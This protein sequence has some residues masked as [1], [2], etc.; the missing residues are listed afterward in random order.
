MN[1]SFGMDF[2]P[3]EEQEDHDR[4]DRMVYLMEVR[5]L[6]SRECAPSV[7]SLWSSTPDPGRFLVKLEGEFGRPKVAVSLCVLW[8]QVR[9]TE[10]IIEMITKLHPSVTMYLWCVLRTRDEYFSGEVEWRDRKVE[11]QKLQTSTK[12]AGSASTMWLFEGEAGK[13]VKEFT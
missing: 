1:I 11:W 13:E 8:E 5:F 4:V 12:V 6:V 9:S 2:P 10:D 3:V 7:A